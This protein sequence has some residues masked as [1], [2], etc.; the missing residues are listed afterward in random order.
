MPSKQQQGMR[1]NYNML[2]A[3]LWG[4]GSTRYIPTVVLKIWY[5]SIMVTGVGMTLRQWRVAIA[6]DRSMQQLRATT[7]FVKES[8][9]SHTLF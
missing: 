1:C 4:L 6:T 3:T 2:S 7:L 9:S 8:F 5:S